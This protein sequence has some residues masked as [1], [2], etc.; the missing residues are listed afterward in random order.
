MYE[1]LLQLPYFQGMSRDEITSILDKVTLEFKK[2]DDGEKIFCQG[3]T[4]DKFTILTNGK[5][6]STIVAPDESYSIAEELCA[7][8]AI[9]PYSL[10]GYSTEYMHSYHSKGCC[11]MLFIDKQFLFSELTKHK[12]FFINLLNLISRKVQKQKKNIWEHTPANIK[13]RIAHFIATRC[14]TISGSKHINIKMET[15]AHILYEARINISKALN[16]LQDEGYMELHRK[17]ITIPSL[18]RLADD[19]LK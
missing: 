1:I 10:F 4:C 19:F 6:T 15:F 9:E 13:G 16:E 11:T 7:P 2:Y 8:F 18:K 17:E 14:E 3:D 5:M 12:I